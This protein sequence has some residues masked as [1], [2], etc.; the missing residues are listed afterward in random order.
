MGKTK[1]PNQS[2]KSKVSKKTWSSE[3]VAN[4]LHEIRSGKS[5]RSS[6]KKYGMAESTLRNRIKLIQEGTEMVGSGR[7]NVLNEQEETQLARCINVLCN[8][9][10]SPSTNEIKDLVR[11]YVRANSITN[12]FNDDRPGKDWL[13]NFMKRQKLSTKKATIISAARKAATANPFIIFDFYEVVEKIIKEKKLNR[14]QIWNCD[15]SGFPTDPSKCKVVAPIGMPGYKTTPGAGRENHTVL[16]TCSAAGRALDPLILFQGK[17]FQSTWKGEKSLPKTMYGIS[18]NGWMTTAVFNDWFI[19]FSKEVKERPLLLIYDGHLSHVSINV[20]E[21]AISEDITIVKFPP[22]VTDKLQP[23]D[24]TCFSPL[25]RKWET[26][27]AE[28]GNVLGPRETL[29]KSTFVD[30]IC[31]IWHQGLSAEN[32]ISGFRATGIYPTDKTK[33]PTNRFDPRL[34]KR[35]EHWVQMG[36]PKDIM[37]DLATSVNT[38]QKFKPPQ[39]TAS[40]NKSVKSSTPN[41]PSYSQKD[42][43]TGSSAII[44]ASS[45]HESMT[46]D[47]NICKVIGPKP[48][49]VSGYCWVPAWT[50]QKDTGDKSFEELVLDKIK[51]PQQKKQVKRRKIDATTKV[52]TDEKYV[53]KLRDGAKKGKNKTKKQIDFDLEEEGDVPEESEEEIIE[54]EESEST[55][56]ID[57]SSG[58][59][60]ASE[61]Q[62]LRQF[63]KYLS[64]EKDE[65][66]INKWYG[67]IWESSKG[68]KKKQGLYVGKMLHRFREDVGG[69]I[70]GFELDCLE[71]PLGETTILK[72]VPRHLGKDIDIFPVWNII[73]AVQIEPLKGGQ[74]NVPNYGLLKERFRNVIT[75]DREA[76]YSDI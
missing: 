65:N 35:Y 43:S 1:Q 8:A 62:S 45:T 15:E 34:L 69:K 64:I 40:T 39:E 6:A 70:T 58:E 2:K 61:E 14:E 23:L 12:P 66:L 57:G 54:E 11:D 75:I 10:F 5:I 44:A 30:L 76:L 24:V 74:W 29:S 52:I 63:W 48:A 55:D 3:S 13:R 42:V 50:L 49:P 73:Q 51:G 36:K 33:Y 47:C 4:A 20:I 67:A 41:L 18:D 19:E 26:L 53:E 68:K 38:P 22:H 56:E 17:N 28:R 16:A 59:E 32:A 25:K 9:G 60:A 31:S 21:M 46:C 27:L 37:E 7:R 71:A 72:S